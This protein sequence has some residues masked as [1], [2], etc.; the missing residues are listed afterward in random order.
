[1]SYYVYLELDNHGYRFQETIICEGKNEQEAEKD[2]YD[3]YRYFSLHITIKV[4][5]VEKVGQV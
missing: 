5:K 4:L 1:M 3:F 2:A